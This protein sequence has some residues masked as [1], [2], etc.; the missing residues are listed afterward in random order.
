GVLQLLVRGA[1]DEDRLLRRGGGRG[2]AGRDE[3]KCR[4]S[5]DHLRPP[6]SPAIKSREGKG[7][8][9]RGGNGPM[10]DQKKLP[11]GFLA[12][13]VFKYFKAMIFLFVAVAA[14]RLSRINPFPTAEQVARF[15]R[16]SPE[17]ELVRTFSRFLTPG[18]AVQIGLVSLFVA[19]V[20]A[21]EG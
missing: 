10:Q 2:R 16:S 18:L 15:F 13:I 6:W 4:Q 5:P 14:L 8:G 1:I 20:F 17:N 3:E 21:T 9:S 7:I 19:A 11:G 12:I